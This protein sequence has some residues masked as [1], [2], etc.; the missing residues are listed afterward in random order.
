[1]AF[2]ARTD[3]DYRAARGWVD[4][5]SATA[6][7]LGDAESIVLAQFSEAAL[8][9][10]TDV[11]LGARK[12]DEV[13]A[14][15]RRMGLEEIAADGITLQAM[16]AATSSPLALAQRYVDEGLALVRER[17]LDLAHTYLLAA[18]SEVELGQGRWDEAAESA[19]L[20]LGERLVSTYPRTRALTSLARIRMR[21][22][23]PEVIPLLDE[24]LALAEPTEEFPRIAPVAA[25]RAE[26]AW[27]AR[28]AH[29]VDRETAA[30]LAEAR[31]RH[32][33]W[34]A[35]ELTTWRWRAGLDDV[36][37]EAIAEPHRL[38]TSGRWREAA[39]LWTTLGRPYEAALALADSDDVD[40]LRDAY[41]VF[42]TLGARPAAEMVAQKLRKRGIRGLPRGPR[43]TTLDNVGGL[44]ARESEVL[45]LV[46]GGLRNGEIADRLFLSSRTVDHHVSAILRKLGSSTRGE[47]VATA[48]R[49]GLVEHG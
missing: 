49:A 14:T 2:L 9:L 6:D 45:E 11:R 42:R 41:G 20:V 33:T 27:L 3:G 46:A 37:L 18:K 10:H 4:R 30:T 24:A 21:R 35:G 44:T 34:L 17:G 5:A 32:S 1:L 38:Q 7:E 22:G 26:F 15:A 43:R 25:A 39:D 13:V 8:L 36:G 23:D 29:L 28:Q 12:L 48:R 31:R 16:V 40:A 47:A 19:E